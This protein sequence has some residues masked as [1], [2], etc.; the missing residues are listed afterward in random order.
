[1]LILGWLDGISQTLHFF[2]CIFAWLSHTALFCLSIW[3]SSFI[4]QWMRTPHIHSTQKTSH[5]K[6]VPW[7]LWYMFVTGL[8]IYSCGGVIRW[9][10]PNL[11]VFNHSES[12]LRNKLALRGAG[13]RAQQSRLL[14]SQDCACST[15]IRTPH[16]C[17]KPGI[18]YMPLSQVLRYSRDWMTEAVQLPDQ[19]MKL[20]KQVH[21]ETRPQNWSW[22][23]FILTK[24][25]NHKYRKTW[26]KRT[27]WRVIKIC[28]MLFCSLDMHRCSQL[29]HCMCALTHAQTHTNKQNNF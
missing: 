13:D 16:P 7:Y 11:R 27:R 24:K 2:S 14:S 19:L 6:W 4:Y 20:K 18:P 26:H 25:T 9:C 28:D 8:H 29:T 5:R 21:G 3:Q 23:V 12:V 22:L 1:M 10:N 17:N 15:V